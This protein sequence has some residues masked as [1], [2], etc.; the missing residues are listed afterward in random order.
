[1]NSKELTNYY[2]DSLQKK[3]MNKVE[4][5]MSSSKKY[6]LNT[7]G[8]E[9]TLLR[10]IFDT[11]LSI[12]AVKEGKKGVISLNKTDDESIDKAVESLM[13]I[14]DNS[15]PDT[16]NDISPMQP[17]GEFVRGE[18]EPDLDKMYVRLSN[19]LTAVKKRYPKIQLMESFL[20]F[21]QSCDHYANSNGVE[22]DS[23][24]GTYGFQLTFASKDG[25]KSSSFNYS[26]FTAKNLDKELLECG[27]IDLL[28]KQSVEQLDTKALEGKF[29]GDVIITP[30]CLGDMIEMYLDVYL[31]DMALIAGTS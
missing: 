27:S 6:E 7:A 8:E 13:E 10:T 11:N 24:M 4:L 1:M 14:V 2:I 20:D 12:A 22:L 25:E 31:R 16:A 17:A 15:E 26:G 30:D 21:T 18:A 29:T 19:F 23:T 9:L 3:G 28:L 5:F